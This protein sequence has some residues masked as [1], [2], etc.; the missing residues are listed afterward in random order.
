M[1]RRNRAVAVQ[2][3]DPFGKLI[4]LGSLRSYV[5]WALKVSAADIHQQ[6][7]EVEGNDVMSRQQVAK[8][9]CR[10][11]SGKESVTDNNQNG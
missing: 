11:A 2:L 1:C 6:C 3:G 7:L 4:W 5:L 8:W 9:C 10:F